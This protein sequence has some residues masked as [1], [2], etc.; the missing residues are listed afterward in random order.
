MQPAPAAPV[1]G[2]GALAVGQ[3][4]QPFTY[5]IV[6]SNTPTSYEVIGAPAW[7]SL[8]SAT[9]A[10]SGV[11]AAPGA[12]TVQLA[13]GNAS[14]TSDLVTLGLLI[15]PAANTPVITS[16]R[17][18]AGTVG[19]AFTYTPSATPASTGYVASGLPGGLAINA[20][21]GAITGTPNVSGTFKVVLTPANANGVGAPATIVL[22]ILPNV[23]FGN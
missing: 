19:T 14:G 15:S 20:A 16:T 7:M 5:Q 18:A 13:A 2:G 22:T 21:T 6:A 11:P 1:V 9:G 17:T 4:G 8:N 3:V 23:T 12:F 10:I